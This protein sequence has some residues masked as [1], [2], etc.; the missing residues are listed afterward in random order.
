MRTKTEF[1]AI[2]EMC[3]ITQAALARELGVEVRSVKRWES[4][5]APQQPP[6]D[7]WDVL[8]RALDVQRQ[9]V[10]FALAQVDE[11][12]A[13]AVRLP[14]WA[15]ADEYADRSTDAELGV[16]LDGESFRRAN[17]NVRALAAVLMAEGTPIIWTR[18]PL[19]HA[20][21]D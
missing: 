6:Q 1:R 3:G 14:Y 13:P 9:V 8:D 2:R 10:D 21:E 17:A 4:D 11:S 12:A 16:S 5:A 18:D 7:A 20:G 15:N 19:G